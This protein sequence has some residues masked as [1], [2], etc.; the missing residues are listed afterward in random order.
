M[1]PRARLLASAG[2]ACQRKERDTGEPTGQQESRPSTPTLKDHRH[3]ER[4][5]RLS[6]TLPDG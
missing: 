1:G 2:N 4:R 5:K 3:Q 6:N